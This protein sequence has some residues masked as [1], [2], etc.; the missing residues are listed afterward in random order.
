MKSIN[1]NFLKSRKAKSNTLII[2]VVIV[3]VL[4]LTGAF[5]GLKIDLSQINLGNGDSSTGTP[6]ERQVQFAVT[7]KYSGT[8]AASKT[9]YVYNSGG[10]LLETLT[11]AS[12]GM[13]NT[14]K[15]YASGTQLYVKYV[16]SNSMVWFPVTVP[17]MLESE[18]EA[19]TYNTVPLEVFSIGTYTGDTLKAG[20]STIADS[21]SYN[22]TASGTTPI[23]KYSIDNSGSDNTGLME[24]YDPV[25]QQSWQIWV[26]VTFSGTGYENIVLSDFDNQFTLGTTNY[27]VERM[28]ATELTKWKVG[29]SYVSGYTGSDDVTWALDMSG[30]TG[31][32]VTMQITVYAYADPVFAAS[33]GGSFGQNTV[34]LAE[35]T[36]TLTI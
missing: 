6:V 35:Q 33:H 3:A 24:S 34:E 25:Y 23:F 31:T 10:A 29:S 7:D 9:L 12:T 11:T 15:P 16:D 8:A 4:A 30:Y 18:I 21:G 36:V 17:N 27:G 22:S 13:I 32:A 19:Q 20:T 2:I 1:K 5:S 26:V 14:A 28:S